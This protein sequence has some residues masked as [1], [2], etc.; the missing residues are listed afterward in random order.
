MVAPAEVDIASSNT[1]R[2]DIERELSS[3]PWVIVDLSQVE[4]IDSTGLS[5]LLSCHHLADQYGGNLVVV[6][7]S[8]RTRRLLGITQLDSMLEIYPTAEDVPLL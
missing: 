6:G 8:D 2:A 1:L 3:N 5:A 4:F 7:P